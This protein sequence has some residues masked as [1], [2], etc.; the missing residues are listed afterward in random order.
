MANPLDFWQ[1]TSWFAIQSNA[2]QE[3]LAVAHV[4]KLD[5]QVFL[6]QVREELS[7]RRG[8]RRVTKALFP[9]YFFS[10]FCPRESLEAVRYA[11][12]VMRVVGS[13]RFPVPVAPGIIAAIQEQVRP[14]GF[15]RFE[16]QDFRPGDRVVLEQ[17][18][19]QGWI[20][21]VQ[22]EQNDGKRVMILLEAI[23]QARLLVEKR[24]LSIAADG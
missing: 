4:A 2:H 17:G 21:Q 20:G 1:K 23:Q 8:I 14:D 22:R 15:I 9:G 11:P 19:F 7:L 24:W 13:R 6:P 10:R 16:A 3:N 5:L 18:P 12:G